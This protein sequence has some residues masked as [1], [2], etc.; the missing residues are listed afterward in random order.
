VVWATPHHVVKLAPCNGSKVVEHVDKLA[1][2]L[3][4]MA[5]KE[6]PV[7]QKEENESEWELE[8]AVVDCSV[9][10]LPGA[11]AEPDFPLS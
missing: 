10:V 9:H 3:S 7:S 11:K 6:C 5:A 4:M 8:A 2:A 1:I